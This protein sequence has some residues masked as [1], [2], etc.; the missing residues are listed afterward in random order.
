MNSLHQLSLASAATLC[1]AVAF[2]ATASRYND[3]AYR[4]FMKLEERALTS[5]P[6][7]LDA[8]LR[9]NNITDEEVREIQQAAS[10]VLPKALVNIS[11][12][13]S[14]CRCEDGPSCKAYAWVTAFHQ[15]K[16]QGLQL[17][18]IGADW[19]IGPVQRWWLDYDRLN[20]RL[21]KVTDYQ[22]VEDA[23]RDRILKFPQCA[24]TS[25]GAQTIAVS[26]NPIPEDLAVFV[27]LKLVEDAPAEAVYCP[28]IDEQPVASKLLRL[29]QSQNSR[30]VAREEC[31][32][33]VDVHQGSFYKPTHRK[34][35]FISINLYA[36]V[37]P[38]RARLQLA[39]Y[40]HGKWALYETV[41]LQKQNGRWRV[42]KI[43][44]RQMS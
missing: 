3:P 14:G 12:V 9:A 24:A 2:P 20:V 8:P 16:A 37:P 10:E 33:V 38:N 35:Y 15:G 36:P 42:V 7:R 17:A 23:R 43:T 5:R 29:L 31:V 44:N 22:K 18:L 30:F 39:Q 19:V 1:L 28:G 13:T 40:H 6:Q 25:Q 11:G 21:E 4:E 32:K 26:P 41:E 27:F 34:A